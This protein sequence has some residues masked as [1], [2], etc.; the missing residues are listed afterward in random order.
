LFTES[1][2]GETLGGVDNPSFHLKATVPNF[3]FLSFF[4]M[5]NVNIELVEIPVDGLNT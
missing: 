5:S 3:F 2:R 1:A 4:W